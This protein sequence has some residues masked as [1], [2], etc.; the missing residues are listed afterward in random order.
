M[1][2]LL[3]TIACFFIASF[4][5]KLGWCLVGW[6]VDWLMD[7]L[8]HLFIDSL[9]LL[10]LD[11]IWFCFDLIWPDLIGWLDLMVLIKWK[12]KLKNML[13]ERKEKR[14][15][16]DGMKWNDMTW[17]DMT[18]MN[19]WMNAWV[20]EHMNLSLGMIGLQQ[21]RL[22]SPNPFLVTHN[23]SRSRTEVEAPCWSKKTLD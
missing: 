15:T 7:W 20:K 8:I 2:I 12:V 10:W 3:H 14:M 5:S 4:N 9:D 19:E 17:H 16:K 21:Q 6:L 1:F 11:S 22:S 23:S 13:H 18:W